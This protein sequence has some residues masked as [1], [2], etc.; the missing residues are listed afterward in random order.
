MADGATYQE[1][2]A[3]AEIIIEEGLE[4]ARIWADQFPNRKADWF[5]LDFVKMKKRILL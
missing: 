2:L 1:A 3:N 5:S 4:T